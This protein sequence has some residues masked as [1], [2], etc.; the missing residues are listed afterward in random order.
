MTDGLGTLLWELRTEKGF[1]LG[2]LAKRAGLD[3]SALSRWK[4][5]KRQPRV[6]ELE[7]TLTAL[8]A[9]DAQRV[10]AFSHVGAPRAIRYLR[11]N[12]QIEGLGAP[13]T[14]G[15]LLRAMR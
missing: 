10:R 9:S 3:K 12:T 7:A 15:D 6:S 8:G 13:P 11:Q 1:S 2:Q 4:A 5:G 14:A